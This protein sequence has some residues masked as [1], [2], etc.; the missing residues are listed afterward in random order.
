MELQTKSV[1]INII[2]EHNKQYTP[3]TK[4]TFSVCA[5][6]VQTI[7]YYLINKCMR[8]GRG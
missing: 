6:F 3:D 5:N 1:R 7:S 8:D 4:Y 2:Q